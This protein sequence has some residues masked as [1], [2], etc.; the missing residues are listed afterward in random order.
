MFSIIA[1]ANSSPPPAST[2]A[3]AY[4]RC[5]EPDD[6]DEQLTRV[7]TSNSNKAAQSRPDGMASIW[8]APACQAV[9][10]TAPYTFPAEMTE[11]HAFRELPQPPAVLSSA[12]TPAAGF[13]VPEPAPYA[14]EQLL[15]FNEPQYDASNHPSLA[16]GA[17]DSGGGGAELPPPPFNSGE[18]LAAWLANAN[19]D[20]IARFISG[21]YA[22]T[23]GSFGTDTLDAYGPPTS[24]PV[25][26]DP[27]SGGLGLDGRHPLATWPQGP[28]GLE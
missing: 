24:A 22:P 3:T 12:T 19:A 6:Y 27:S 16:G 14:W 17:F 5:R 10:Q 15:G 2:R 21:G 1:S 20:D 25:F 26:V 18:Q 23:P 9:P 28:S 13:F 7:H 8:R 11:L 4:K